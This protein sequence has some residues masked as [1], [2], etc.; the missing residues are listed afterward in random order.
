MKKIVIIVLALLVVGCTKE[1]NSINENTLDNKVLTNE[2]N[3][4]DDS[5]IQDVYVDDNPVKISI[6]AEND[7]GSLSKVIDK[8]ETTWQEK[9]DIVV[10]ATLPTD[11]DNPEYDYM[12]NMWPKYDG[13]YEDINYKVGWNVTFKLKNGEEIN[14]TLLKPSDAQSYYDYLEIYLYDD[15]NVPIGQ[16]HSHLLDED[17]TDDTIMDAIKLTAGDKYE[18]IDGSITVTVFTYDDD[19]DFDEN[20][21]YRGKSLYKVEIYNR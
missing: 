14:S 1:E 21:N 5:L 4:T 13:E 19:T 10:L 17:I 2:G 12:P 20:G 6:Y 15:V 9:K 16:W 11:I 7:E 8:Y 3:N 18:E